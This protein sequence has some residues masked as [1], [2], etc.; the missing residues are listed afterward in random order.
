[1]YIG[2]TCVGVCV[3]KNLSEQVL[4]PTGGELEMKKP[5]VELKQSDYRMFWAALLNS[6]TSVYVLLDDTHLLI[7]C[8]FLELFSEEKNK[9]LV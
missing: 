5:R 6:N 1:M 8:L 2:C 9:Y 4:S 7:L 3:Y